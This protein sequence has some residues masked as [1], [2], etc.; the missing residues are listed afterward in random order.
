MLPWDDPQCPS[1]H[2]LILEGGLASLD[3]MPRIAISWRLFKRVT[4]LY[5]VMCV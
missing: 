4:V 5:K 2:V 1:L 3:Y